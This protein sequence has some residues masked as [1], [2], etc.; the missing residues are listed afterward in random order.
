[1]SVIKKRLQR[2]YRPKMRLNIAFVLLTTFLLIVSFCS[3]H[4][5]QG[6]NKELKDTEDEQKFLQAQNELNRIIL[7]HPKS[8]ISSD[9]KKFLQ[10]EE[11]KLSINVGDVPYNLKTKLVKMRLIVLTAEMDYLISSR[12]SDCHK[13]CSIWHEYQHIL[14]IQAG[15]YPVFDNDRK[16]SWEDVKLNFENELEAYAA[17][18]ELATELGCLE[19]FDAGKAFMKN[20]K[21]GLILYL[22][23]RGRPDLYLKYEDKLLEE[24][25]EKEE[26]WLR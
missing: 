11:V 18:F 7:N 2:M 22:M 23:Y 26:L 13:F 8:E 25:L 20:G 12:W 4:N 5:V 19:E 6:A 10:K 24:F 21:K 14:Q 9:L 1:M 3:Q 17:Q 16:I 15:H